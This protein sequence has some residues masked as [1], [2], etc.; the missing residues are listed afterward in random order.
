MATRL[1]IV[2]HGETAWNRGNIYRGTYDIPLNDNGRQ[3][4][5]LTAAALK[6]YPI[7]IAYTSPL[8]RAAETARITLAPHGIEASPHQDLLDFDYG[9]WTGKQQEEVRQTWPAEFEEWSARPHQARPPGGTTLQ[10][11]SDRCT[12]MMVEVAARHD[13]STVALF[14]HRVVNKLLVLGALGLGLD[15][16]PFIVQGNCS[17]NEILV[18]DGTFTI[19]SLN[20]TAHMIEGGVDILTADF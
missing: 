15:R 10:E 13:G 6:R 11:V 8:S 18:Q 4:A 20:N 9:E 5:R 19:E 7:D 1:I 12:T 2:R 17:F 14:S 3:Q 16:F